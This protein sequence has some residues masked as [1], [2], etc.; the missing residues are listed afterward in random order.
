MI[1]WFK[2]TNPFNS[3]QA[4]KKSEAAKLLRETNKLKE[5]KDELFQMIEANCSLG[6]TTC[7]AGNHALFAKHEVE[8]T[9][10]LNDY[11]YKVEKSPAFTF[12]GSLSVSSYLIG[13]PFTAPIPAP[14]QPPTTYDYTINWGDKETIFK[15]EM[16]EILAEPASK[17]RIIE[18]ND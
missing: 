6:H 18:E 10:L 7:S 11:G 15:N 8:L 4:L 1:K 13:P 5:Y 3:A 17:G 2:K 12:T 14:V 16:R 9:K